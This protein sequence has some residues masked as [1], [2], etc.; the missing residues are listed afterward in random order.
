MRIDMYTQS[1]MIDYIDGY[2]DSDFIDEG[3]ICIHVWI[4]M[5]TYVYIFLPGI[6]EG[7]RISRSSTVQWSE[8]IKAVERKVARL[9]EE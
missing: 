8:V 9:K 7:A 3:C 5:Q 1:L 6:N 2:N 4:Y